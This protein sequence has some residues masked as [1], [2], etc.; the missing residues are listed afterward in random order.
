[1]AQ[2][3]VKYKIQ[4]SNCQNI[5]FYWTLSFLVFARDQYLWHNFGVEE[6]DHKMHETDTLQG[7][8]F[9]FYNIYHITNSYFP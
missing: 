7:I 3:P 2:S 1:M 5:N 9:F 6:D 8:L 4:I